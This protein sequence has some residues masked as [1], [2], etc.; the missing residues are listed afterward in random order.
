MKGVGKRFLSDNPAAIPIHCLAHCVNL[1]LQ[2]MTRRCNSIKQALNFAMEL[3]Q[4]I[5]LSPKRQVLF[6]NIQ[7]QQECGKT[8]GIRTLCPTRWTVRT[9]ALKTIVTNYATLQEVASN[10]SDD[11]SRRANGVLDKFVIFYGLSL[12]ILLFSITEQLSTTLQTKADDSV[13]AV[14]VCIRT[15]ERLITAE[16]FTRFFTKVKNEAVTL[17]AKPELPRARRPPKRVDDGATPHVFSSIDEYFRKEY[18]EAIDLIK[19]ELESRFSKPNFVLVREIEKV[20]FSSANGECTSIPEAVQSLYSNDLD[21]EKLHIQLQMLQDAVHSTPMNGI[22]IK[23]VTRIQTLCE[24]FNY[25]PSLKKLFT[26]VD[27][28]LL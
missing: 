2:D 16:E 17:C 13:H 26:E 5:K 8:T 4:L 6:E 14:N 9:G 20:L 23:K 10:G 7:K 1:C 11:C 24:L 25:Q 12:L 28:L 21:M 19:G 18:Y 22:A 15:L 27:K 3:I